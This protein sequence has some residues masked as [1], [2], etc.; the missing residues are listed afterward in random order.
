VSAN[1]I[2]EGLLDVEKINWLLVVGSGGIYRANLQLL[3]LNPR[4]NKNILEVE[5]INR[6]RPFGAGRFG[7]APAE[8]S[9]DS[10]FGR[11]GGWQRIR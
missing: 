8:R 7:T 10:A 11:T 2:A 5:K 1:Q 4:E 3:H 9:G 6:L